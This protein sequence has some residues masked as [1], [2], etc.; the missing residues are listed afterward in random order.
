MTRKELLIKA[1]LSDDV[2]EEK[3]EQAL[4]I[5]QGRDMRKKEVSGYLST[6]D[7]IKF[8]NLSRCYLW[9]LRKKGLPS[10]KVGKRILF[11][12]EEIESWMKSNRIR[13]NKS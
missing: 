10:Y 3:L 5:L 7:A 2:S 11:K 6:N 9:I 4:S 8:L 12:P 13:I 1:V